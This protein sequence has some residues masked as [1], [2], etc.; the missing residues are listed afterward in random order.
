MV[1]ALISS[2]KLADAMKT[3]T[4]MKGVD[5]ATLER[6]RAETLLAQKDSTGLS[7]SSKEGGKAKKKEGGKR[8]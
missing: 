7:G 8:R 4:G 3:I 2:G 5:A 1:D 6:L